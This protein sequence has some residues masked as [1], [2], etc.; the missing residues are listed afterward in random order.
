MARLHN[1]GFLAASERLGLAGSE[2]LMIGDDIDADVGGAQAAGLKG[3]LAKTGKFRPAD[4]A[5]AVRPD[6]VFES[7]ADLPRWW[8]R[9]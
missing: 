3:A 5:G 6:V 8:N 1:L 2:V 7:V 4:L 9:E